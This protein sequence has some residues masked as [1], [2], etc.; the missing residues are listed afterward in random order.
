MY[1][2]KSVLKTLIISLAITA[3]SGNALA[4]EKSAPESSNQ[5]PEIFVQMGF[6]W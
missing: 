5:V 6:L 1:K 3:C 2:T 4:A